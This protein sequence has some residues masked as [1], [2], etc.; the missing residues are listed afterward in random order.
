MM[1]VCP[2]CG[3]NRI[4]YDDKAGELKCADCGYVIEDNVIDSGPEWRAYDTSQYRMRARADPSSSLGTS[5]PISSIIKDKSGKTLSAEKKKRFRR[6]ARTHRYLEN[7][8]SLTQAEIEIERIVSGLRLPSIVKADALEYYKKARELNLIKGKSYAGFAS[9]CI[10]AACKARGYVCDVGDLVRYSR[11]KDRD[12]KKYYRTLIEYKIAG[13]V[14]P[15]KPFQYIPSIASKLNLP[16]E[17][18]RL[19]IQILHK[20]DETKK[21]QS[22]TPKGVAAASLYIAAIILDNKRKQ[23]DI[24]KAANIATPTLRKNLKNILRSLTIEVFV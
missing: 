18:Q 9:A 5:I 15:S 14:K 21:F 4:I 24:A 7:Y 3:S 2:K 16:M 23:S 12:L 19:A 1:G 11:V 8:R 20:T 6:I 13:V 10:L 17:V 22:K